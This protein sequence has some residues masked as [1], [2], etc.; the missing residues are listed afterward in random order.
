MI[1][2]HT[3]TFIVPTVLALSAGALFVLAISWMQGP[4]QNRQIVRFDFR[5]IRMGDPIPPSVA[6]LYSCDPALAAAVLFTAP[7]PFSR[8][9]LLHGA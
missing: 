6:T 3:R 1:I 5:G 8:N 2:M 4:K 9:A 7:P